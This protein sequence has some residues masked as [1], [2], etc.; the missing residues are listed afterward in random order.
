MKKVLTIIGGIVVGVIII[1]VVIYLI[2]S[3]TSKKMVCTSNE[4]KITIMYND[5]TITGYT[6]KNISYNMDEQKAYAE[7]VGIEAYLDEFN[8]WFAN[9]TTS[10]SCTKK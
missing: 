5:K 8:T 4:G 1:G 10:G 2:V 9:N 7:Q 6:A 3:L